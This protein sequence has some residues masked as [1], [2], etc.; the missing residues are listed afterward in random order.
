V[1]CPTPTLCLRDGPY[2]R[3]ARTL[4]QTFM[5]ERLVY[6]IQTYPLLRWTIWAARCSS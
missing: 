1:P 4:S 6:Q 5:E 2:W 3:A